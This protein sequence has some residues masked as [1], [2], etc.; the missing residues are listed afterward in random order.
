MPKLSKLQEQTVNLTAAYDERKRLFD[1]LPDLRLT[2][3]DRAT[4]IADNKAAA[5][6]FDKLRAAITK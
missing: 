4:A 5:V 6:E 1:K 3:V 2:D